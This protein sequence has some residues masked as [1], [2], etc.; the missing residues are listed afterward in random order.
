M[1]TNVLIYLQTVPLFRQ[2][3]NLHTTCATAINKINKSYTDMRV[4]VI[5]RTV[6]VIRRTVTVIRRIVTLSIHKIK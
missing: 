2:I 4:T 3:F 1:N 6:T 5:R